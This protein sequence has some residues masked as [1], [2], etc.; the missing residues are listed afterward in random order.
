M[1]LEKAP[2]SGVQKQEKK[3]FKTEIK[4]RINPAHISAKT[5]AKLPKPKPESKNM[6]ERLKDILEKWKNMLKEFPEKTEEK[7]DEGII[8]EEG[9]GM[10][11]DEEIQP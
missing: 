8:E 2:K 6:L 1:A 9:E 7:G 11:D 4:K 3:I 10:E 5:L